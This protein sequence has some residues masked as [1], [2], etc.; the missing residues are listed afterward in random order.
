MKVLVA[1]DEKFS[2]LLVK[3]TLECLNVELV[4][5]EDGTS[6]LEKLSSEKF[7]ICILDNIMPGITGIELINKLE[8]EYL[9]EHIIMLTA[10]VQKEDQLA[11]EA[12]GVGH[13]VSK[14]YS[15]NKLYQLIQ[16]LM[17]INSS[18]T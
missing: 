16:E 5:A 8:G 2:R 1:D 15:P 3:E 6:A 12:C 4:F 13:Y 7:H 10:R 17:S 9:P 11:A 14:P 18:T